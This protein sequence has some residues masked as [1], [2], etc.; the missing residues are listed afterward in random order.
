MQYHVGV[1]VTAEKVVAD[2]REK[3]RHQMSV[4]E[5]MRMSSGDDALRKDKRFNGEWIKTTRR[6]TASLLSVAKLPPSR[7]STH[8]RTGIEF[9]TR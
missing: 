5:G 2:A 6:Y 8:E 4:M 1:H 3:H 7:L 9:L